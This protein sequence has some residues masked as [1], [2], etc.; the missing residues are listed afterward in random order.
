MNASPM[1]AKKYRPRIL[2]P[3][4]AFRDPWKIGPYTLQ[5]RFFDVSPGTRFGAADRSRRWFT[6][7]RFDS[8]P[9]WYLGR[10]R[11]DLPA[12]RRVDSPRVLPIA[13]MDLDAESPWYAHPYVDGPRLDEVGWVEPLD[14]EDDEAPD[15]R[16]TRLVALG[17]AEALA[18]IHAAGMVHGDLTPF[19]VFLG[20][21][22]PVV[23]DLGA[24][25]GPE[26]TAPWAQDPRLPERVSPDEVLDPADDVFAWAV[27]VVG[28]HL[29]EHPYPGETDEE[30]FQKIE[31]G[32]P[33]L[34]GLPEDLVE[35]VRAALHPD[36]RRRPTA[37]QLLEHLTG[38]DADP[39]LDPREV[40]RAAFEEHWEVPETT[41]VEWMR[42]ERPFEHRM[43]VFNL[44]VWIPGVLIGLLVGWFLD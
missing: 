24:G 34:E 30:V 25:P 10:L 15:P 22:G 7:R 37:A 40:S 5:G 23:A 44:F 36:R 33:E 29:D 38:A 3:V 42:Y 43:W 21:Q 32:E 2:T 14:E 19:N 11:E 9:P 6:V 8:I 27:L 1:N 12:A 20:P 13:D 39:R 17:L 28:V 31:R 18:D 26:R 4:R 41:L 35:P 16:T